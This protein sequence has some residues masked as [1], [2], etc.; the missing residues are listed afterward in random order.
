MLKKLQLGL[1]AA[2]IG[3]TSFVGFG[4]GA[5]VQA[6]PPQ[7]VQGGGAAGLVAAVIGVQDVDVDVIR[8]IDVAFRDINVVRNVL[9]N[10]PFL[11]NAN[12]EIITIENALNNNVVTVEALNDL[13]IDVDDVVA[14]VQ[15]LGGGVLVLT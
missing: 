10:S 2:V 12:V 11:N 4:A 5:P 9:N 14:V 8:D 13:N 6:Q 1:G 15:V 3:A 7:N